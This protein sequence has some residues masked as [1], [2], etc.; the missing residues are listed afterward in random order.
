MSLKSDVEI[1]G[2]SMLSIGTRWRNSYSGILVRT[3]ALIGVNSNDLEWLTKFSTT[4]SIARPVCDSWASYF[5]NTVSVLI[6][7]PAEGWHSV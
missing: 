2:N 5:W 6:A 1:R 3:Y 7:L 4:W